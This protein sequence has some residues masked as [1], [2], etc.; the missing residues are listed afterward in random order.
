M[1]NGPIAERNRGK[2]FT[3]TAA[4]FSNLT[5]LFRRDDLRWWFR[6]QSNRV[7]NVGTVRSSWAPRYCAYITL[8]WAKFY[9]V[10]NF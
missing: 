9:C 7:L 6:R 2:Y 3:K 8:F 10:F 4:G 1:A 5:S